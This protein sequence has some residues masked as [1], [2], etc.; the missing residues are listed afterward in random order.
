MSRFSKVIAK[1][2]VLIYSTALPLTFSTNSVAHQY[3]TLLAGH[4]KLRMARIDFEIGDEQSIA[5]SILQAFQSD[6]AVTS[7]IFSAD[8]HYVF[9][10]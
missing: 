3:H 9:S 4:S 10:A 1:S 2:P 5:E 8:S 6:G 7:A